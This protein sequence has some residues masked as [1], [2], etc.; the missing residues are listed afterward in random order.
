MAVEDTSNY[1]IPEHP[2]RFPLLAPIPI[3]PPYPS[4]PRVRSGIVLFR[5]AARDPGLRVLLCYS[6][7][8]PY[9]TPFFTLL[10]CCI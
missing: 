10:W 5:S 1:V 7:F 9:F 3:D 2:S 6:F 8:I 4:G